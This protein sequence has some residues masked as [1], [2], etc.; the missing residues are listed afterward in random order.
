MTPRTVPTAPTGWVSTVELLRL[1]GITYRQADYWTRLGF[2]RAW[3]EGTPGSGQ[4]RAYSPHE[5]RVAVVLGALV[6]AGVD[7]S[8]A[9][10]A[11]RAAVI[12]GDEWHTVL[13][14]GLEVSGR[15]PVPGS[16]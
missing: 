2:L 8:A 10:A 7:V 14:G 12:H 3:P 9:H 4:A 1:A 11:A 13:D 15:L 6:Q 5:L 16:P